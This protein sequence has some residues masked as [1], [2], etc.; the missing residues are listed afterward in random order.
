MKDNGELTHGPPEVLARWHQHFYRLLNVDS[1]FSEEVLEG[2]TVLPLLAELD[3]PP[4]EDDLLSALSKLKNGKAGGKIKSASYLE[5]VSYG[6]AP[7]LD[8][9]LMLMQDVWREGKVVGDW[10]DAAS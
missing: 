3:T 4:S 10:K 9:L 6:G 1:E 5:L 2:V 8:R 7:L